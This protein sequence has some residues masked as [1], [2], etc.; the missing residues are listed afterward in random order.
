[1]GEDKLRKNNLNFLHEYFDNNNNNK[2]YQINL[3]SLK[4]IG[5]KRV[6]LLIRFLNWASWYITSD[7][8]GVQSLHSFKKKYFLNVMIKI[9]KNLGFLCVVRSYIKL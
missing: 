9:Y 3:F 6:W 1:M 2:P 7:S 5:K 4:N 8:P